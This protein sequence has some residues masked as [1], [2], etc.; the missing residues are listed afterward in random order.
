MEV[1]TTRQTKRGV[2]LGYQCYLFP[3]FFYWILEMF[4]R[5]GIFVFG[6]SFHYYKCTETHTGIPLY[7][8]G[9]IS[10]N[11]SDGVAIL[12]FHCYFLIIM[13]ISSSYMIKT[14]IQTKQQNDYHSL[15]QYK[16]S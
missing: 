8:E 6:F 14:A 7:M 3:L 9:I 1:P 2:C 15:L 4:R 10:L 16:A 13:K 12:I 11:C 5:Y